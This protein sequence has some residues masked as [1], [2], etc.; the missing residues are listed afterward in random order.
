MHKHSAME[1]ENS[2]LMGTYKRLP[3]SFI[4]GQGAWLWDDQDKKYLDALGGIAVAALG[5]GHPAMAKALA[6]QAHTLIHTSNLY[7]IPL[8]EDLGRK[9]CALSG[10]SKAFFCNS[11]AE[12]N[13]AAIKI[14]RKYGHQLNIQTPCILVTERSFHGR[15]LATLTATGNQKI[16]AGFEPLPVGF[17]RVCF[18]DVD[19]VASIA[20][21]NRNV[22]AVLVEPI[23]G[24]GGINIPHPGYLKRVREICSINNWL[25]MIDEIQT[26]MGRTGNWFAFQHDH[27]VPDVVTIAKALGNGIPIGACLARGL[28][29]EILTTGSHGTTFGGNPFACRAALTVI[30]EIERNHLVRRAG[31]LGHRILNNLQLQLKDESKM[32]SIRGKGL[33][34]ALELDRPCAQLVSICLDQGLLINVTAENVVRLLP[35]FILSDDEAD[36]LVQRLVTA[37][38]QYN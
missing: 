24:E 37:I 23:Q 34:I 21:N 26:G 36:L 15:T 10:M 19:A 35:P 18:D 20:N 32:V 29:A 33:M 30:D 5:H 4:R 7:R 25:L 2:Y 1:N 12:A 16:Q 31:E 27:I 38:R 17:T 3:I 11:G 22:V 28:A 9:L 8:Q 14:A 13:E 6:D